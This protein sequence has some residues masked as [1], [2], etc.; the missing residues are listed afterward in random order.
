MELVIR[1]EISPQEED[2][3]IEVPFEMPAGVERM[4]VVLVTQLYGADKSVVN[5]G[6]KDAQR[7]RGWS[8][9]ARTEFF[10]GTEKATPGYIPGLLAPGPWAVLLNP[11]RIGETGCSVILTV[12]FEMESPRW[13]KG[14]LHAH[15]VHSD[16]AHTMLEVEQMALEAGLDFL[17]L[18]D[19]NTVSQNFVYPKDSEL[20][21]IPGVELTT[22]FGHCNFYGVEQPGENFLTASF[23]QAKEYIRIARERGAK[24]SLNHPHC[25]NCGW[26]WDFD[27]DHDWV[28][29][30]NGPWREDNELTLNWWHEQLAAG[31][32]LV[33]VGGSDFHRVQPHAK[34]GM[35]TNW[36]YAESRTVRGILEAV[37]RGRLYLSYAPEGPRLTMNADRWMMGDTISA[38]EVANGLQLVM[39]C[40]GLEAGDSIRLLTERGVEREWIVE[41][42]CE[43]KKLEVRMEE[44]LFYRAEIRRH[45]AEAGQTLLALACNPIYIR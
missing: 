16:G 5:L 43:T 33:A 13:L 32:K 14:D 44:R 11:R 31:R 27:V 15:T 10:I 25:R 41:P 18:T 6:I 22:R 20:V 36:V 37:D 23:D 9:G 35:P 8:G 34:H 24:I 19:H 21:F 40:H 30:W 17:A 12:R 39:S 38:D 28:E 42:G 4:H 1:R 2:S 7:M 29:I 26:L 45:F 3:Y